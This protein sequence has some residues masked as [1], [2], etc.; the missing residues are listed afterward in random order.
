M[1]ILSRFVV[2]P[3]VLVL[4]FP[5]STEIYGAEKGQ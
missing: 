2:M 5:F 4:T 1:P 3:R